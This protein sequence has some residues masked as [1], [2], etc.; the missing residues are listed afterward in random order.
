VGDANN[1]WCL[2]CESS[3]RKAFLKAGG[4]AAMN[5]NGPQ[6]MFVDLKHRPDHMEAWNRASVDELAAKWKQVHAR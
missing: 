1:V 5:G 3:D 4:F 6:M 2:W